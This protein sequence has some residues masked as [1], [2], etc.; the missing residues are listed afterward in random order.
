MSTTY[1]V[2]VGLGQPATGDRAW[3]SVCNANTSLLDVNNAL[4][5]LLVGINETPSA[6]TN[7]KVNA[8]SF[9]KGDGT[10]GSY[11]GIANFPLAASSTTYLWLSD[12]G[13]LTTGSSYPTSAHVRLAHVS[14]STGTVTTIVDDRMGAATCGTGLGFVLKTG[15]TMTGT[16]TIASPSTGIS[17]FIV[18]PLTP[19]VGFFGVAPVAQRASIAALVNNTTGAAS[20]TM[21]DV[22][23]TFSQS[24]IDANFSSVTT[25]INAIL[26]ALKAFGFVATP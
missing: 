9:I 11:A 1:T 16:L 21:V 12:S 17:A 6:T 19:A 4:G 5:N 15:D 8:G 13:V 10:V 3:G 24:Q 22:G 2:N 26:A 25:K 7:V 18:N 14:T 20:N 23:P